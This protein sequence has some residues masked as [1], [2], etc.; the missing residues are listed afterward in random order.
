MGSQRGPV[1]I[2]GLLAAGD[3][4]GC[5]LVQCG[6]EWVVHIKEQPVQLGVLLGCRDDVPAAHQRLD[7][8]HPGRQDGIAQASAEEPDVGGGRQVGDRL[9]QATVHERPQPERPVEGGQPTSIAAAGPHFAQPP[10]V[11]PQHLILAALSSELDGQCR[12][13]QPRLD[14]ARGLGLRTPL[15][16]EGSRGLPV[17]PS[18][19]PPCLDPVEAGQQARVPA[20]PLGCDEESV[21]GLPG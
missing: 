20:G 11:G 13:A 2:L 5:S 9:T 19:R 8:V 4:R 16:E 17:P 12:H 1:V 6:R 18:L 21:G 14:E 7:Q 15:E 3:Q 10:S